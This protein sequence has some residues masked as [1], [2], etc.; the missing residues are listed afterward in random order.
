M[1]RIKEG[2]STDDIPN[3]ARFVAGR[4]QFSRLSDNV[5]NGIEASVDWSSLPDHVFR[6]GVLPMQ[7]SSGCPYNCAFC[8]LIR[9]DSKIISIKP[10]DTII[11]ELKAVSSHGVRYIRF[12]DDN[13]RLGKL[14]LKEFCQRLLEECIQVQWMVMTRVSTLEYMDAELLRRA[15]CLE[16]A[17]GL[18]SADAQILRNMNKKSDPTKYRPVIRKLLASG[19]NCT[20]YFLFGF[21]GE[22]DD[23]ALGTR[24][25]IKSIE[26]PELDG[27]LSWDLYL[28]FLS[29][30]SPI[31]EIQMREKYG[32]RG[33][34]D[35]WKHKT[36]DSQRAKEHIEAA[37]M[38]LEN[39]CQLSRG[40]NLDMLQSLSP[41]QRKKFSITRY[42]LAK[43]AR[44][45]QIRKEDILTSFE[46]IIKTVK[47][48]KD[49]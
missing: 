2:R 34:L 43:A 40:D 32:L 8:N 9:S 29:P 47:S 46:N 31:Y 3:T 6:S 22:T 14:D 7:A 15:G 16:V 28:F 38:E 41:R 36:M 12:V 33:F 4:Y 45:N 25:F 10:I 49:D 19:I 20:C 35:Q 42:K 30:L 39:S 44:K 13:F 11:E 17:L 27:L 1:K 23:T 37:Y 48:R 21:P 24:E 18:E 26:F 5:V